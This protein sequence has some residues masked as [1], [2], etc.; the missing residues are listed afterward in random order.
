MEV[1]FGNCPYLQVPTNAHA[2][3]GAAVPDNAF[4]TKEG[5]R[6]DFNRDTSAHV[7]DSQMCTG[8]GI[9]KRTLLL[10]GNH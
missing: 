7:L 1:C 10:S 9:P 8:L 6:T 4:E 3:T 2:R 5:G